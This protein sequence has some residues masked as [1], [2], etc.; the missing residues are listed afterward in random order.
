MQLTS[1]IHFAINISMC[2]REE[3]VY[4]LLILSEGKNVMLCLKARPEWPRNLSSI[5]SAILPNT[6][7]SQ[8][9]G[10]RLTPTKTPY[11]STNCI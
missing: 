6:L 4:R 9:L 7:C 8:V 5:N 11:K 2:F 1:F 3:F 10:S